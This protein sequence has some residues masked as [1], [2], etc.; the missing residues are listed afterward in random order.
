M[1][2]NISTA[3]IAS[4]LVVG[5]VGGAFVNESLSPEPVIGETKIIVDTENLKD[6]DSTKVELEET[7]VE[8]ISTN[9][10]QLRAEREATL[11]YAQKYTA[12]CNANINI[13][14]SQISAFDALIAKVETEVKKYVPEVTVNEE[15]VEPVV[16]E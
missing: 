5:G 1:N 11:K 12:Q 3:I 15:V 14:Q 6:F 4:A 2:N 7:N 8:K 10:E 16:T 9:V 13:F